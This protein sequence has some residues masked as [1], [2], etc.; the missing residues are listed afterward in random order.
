M[1]GVWIVRKVKSL[2]LETPP[3]HR[4]HR[5]RPVLTLLLALA[6]VPVAYESAT[7]CIANWRSMLGTN[8]HVE[9]PVL[10][11]L[12]IAFCRGIAGFQRSLS[13]ALSKTPWNPSVV[14]ACGIGLALLASSALRKVG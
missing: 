14:I 12:H 2:D 5:G 4:R 6:L 8:A 1:R 7:R 11:T 9:T 3:S 13:R 10:D